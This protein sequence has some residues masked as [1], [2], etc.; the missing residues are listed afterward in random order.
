MSDK[1]KETPPLLSHCAIVMDGNGR[2]ATEKGLPR[3]AGHKAG[4]ET[5][6]MA[7]ETC[8]KQGIPYLTLFAFS[9]ENWS[10]P[11]QEVRFLMQLLKDV[12]RREI[13]ALHKESVRF[14]VIGDRAALD[15]RLVELIN[16]AERKTAN[17]TRFT[18]CLAINYGGRW[19]ITQASHNIALAVQ[20][21]ELAAEDITE[22]C[23][24][25]FLQ[26]HDFPEPDLFIRTSGEHRISNFLLWQMAYTEMI[27]VDTYWPDFSESD[28]MDCLNAYSKRSR[29]YGGARSTA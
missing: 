11:R 10:R 7:V 19:D 4:V 14:R 24:G 22:A 8:L 1:T 26:T 5:V 9:S 2:W 23:V 17:N 12:L 18:L 20:K 21:G 16:E 28:F 27:F 3:I 13:D 6:R 25:R 15:P 29:L